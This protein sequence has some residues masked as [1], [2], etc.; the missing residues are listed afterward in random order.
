MMH[1]DLSW[2]STLGCAR[3]Q[4]LTCLH[5]QEQVNLQHSQGESLQSSSWHA[6][7]AQEKW[8]TPEW[9]NKGLQP[10]RAGLPASRGPSWE[11][12]GTVMSLRS[13]AHTALAAPSVMA[14]NSITTWPSNIYDLI[15]T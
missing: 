3:V 10:L 4:T 2:G 9:H 12:P 7:R 15:I 11:S 14:R 13:R 8:G 5:I 6:Q 1:T